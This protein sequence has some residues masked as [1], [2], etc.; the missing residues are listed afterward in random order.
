[1]NSSELD[2]LCKLVKQKAANSILDCKHKIAIVSWTRKIMYQ[3]ICIRE[4]EG[5][6]TG[7]FR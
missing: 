4:H 5:G 7:N 2:I 3:G 6:L 1:M